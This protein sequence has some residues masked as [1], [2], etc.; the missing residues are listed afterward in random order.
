MKTINLNVVSIFLAILACLLITQTASAADLF[1]VPDSDKS[2][3]WFLDVLFPENL[4]KSPLASTVTI[5]NS[6]VLLIGGILA[7]Y[8]L[9]AG[10]MSTAHDGEM[11]GKKWSSMWLPVRTALGTAMIL[12]AA[13]GFCAAQ[14]AVLWMINQ[15]VGLADTVWNTY[16]SNPSDGAV[17]TTSASYQELDR[18]AKTAFINNVCMLKADELW[19]KSAEHDIFPHVTP[20]FEMIPEKGKYLYIYNYG[21][22]N[23]GNDMNKNLLISKA[24][25]GSITLTDPK[26]K[27]DYDNQAEAQATIAAGGMYMA[28]MPQD[29]KTKISDVVE[30]QNVAFSALDNRM[31]T[32]AKQYVADN[33][34]DIQAG[35]NSAITSYVELIDTAVR[36]AFSSGDQWDDFKDNVKKDGWFMAGAWSMKLIRIQDAINGAAHNLPVVGQ[37]T[38]EYGDIDR[39]MN[40]I[41]TKVAQDM[42]R[43]TTASRYA[44]GIDAQI[45]QDENTGGKRKADPRNND[46]EKLVSQLQDG[47]NKSISGAMAGFISSSVINGRK[48]GEIVAFSTDTT[49]AN[50]KAINPLLAVKGLG[51]SISTAGWVL[52]GTAAGA[53]ALLSIGST[54]SWIGSALGAINVVM[55]I[56]IPLWIAGDTLAVVIPMLPYVM[57]F[58]VCIGWM[59]L[60][61]EAMIAAPLWVITHL[62]PDGDGVVGRGGAGYGLVLSLTMRPALMVTGLIAAYTMLPILGGILNE[63]FSGAFGMVAGGNI[64]VIESLAFIAVYIAMMF[65]LV[66]K[67]LSLI[68]IIPDEIMKWLGVHGGQGMSGYAQSASKGVESAV[69]TQAALNQIS[70]VSNGLSNLNDKYKNNKERDQNKAL[71]ETSRKEAAQD[72]SQGKQGEA[73]K[74]ASALRGHISTNGGNLDNQNENQSL[75][76]ANLANQAADAAE[77]AA[78][79][80]KGAGDEITASQY[81]ASAG[82]YRQMA[83]KAANRV[84]AFDPNNKKGLADLLPQN[85]RDNAE[86]AKRSDPNFGADIKDFKASDSGSSDGNGASGGTDNK[87]QEPGQ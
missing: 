33:N 80:A 79:V 20:E 8:T 61:L 54:A 18:I 78:E 22:K 57:W 21:A 6:A 42:A 29:I 15:G 16:A 63:T 28:Y 47:A 44:N 72:R 56:V 74:V 48:Q 62:H 53:G 71:A 83:Q 3:L 75:E 23:A 45:K 9:I 26:A 50:L 73:N 12:P 68:H 5:L 69:F 64:G 67:S 51:D 66:K 2:K 76:S 25:C 32:L 77:E 81:E 19:K 52:F 41:M 13:G 24:A 43:S 34:I 86:N 55:P 59:I 17:I 40:G 39:N 10:T 87:P 38:M 35:I 60:C 27:A 84:V 30:A 1:T 85:L 36:T 7:A 4:A 11:L 65:T 82:K 58:G 46:T 31:N 14:V 70:H 49:A 37:Q